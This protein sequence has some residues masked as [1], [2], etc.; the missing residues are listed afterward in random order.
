MYISVW[1]VR[2]PDKGNYLE[3]RV[4]TSRKNK[5]TGEYEQRFSDGYVHFIS[6]AKEALEPYV[7]M[8]SERGPVL[9]ANIPG[10]GV[11]NCHKGDDGKIVYDKN[12]HYSVFE[13]EVTSGNNASQPQSRP[14]AN[15]FMN[16]PDT[17]SEE[18]PFS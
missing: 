13:L 10:F 1:E 14:S 17:D 9:R 3:G 6:N 16:V 4:T 15:S 5:Q 8:T 11:E 12:P 2:K 7:G 18:L